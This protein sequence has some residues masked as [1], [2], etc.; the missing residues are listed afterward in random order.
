MGT[1]LRR[2]DFLKAA[3]PG[4]IAKETFEQRK[5]A[6]LGERCLLTEN[7]EN[8]TSNHH[9]LPDRLSAVLELAGNAYLAY[10]RP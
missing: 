9:S 4:Q 5:T 8:L 7:R 1:K 6:L 2:R 3:L 10:K